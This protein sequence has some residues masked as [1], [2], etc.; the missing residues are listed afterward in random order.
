MIDKVLEQLF[1][2]G[3]L[4]V[5]GEAAAN[6]LT[7]HRI[8]HV[9]TLSITP[10]PEER[11]VDGVCYTF[12]QMADNLAQDIVGSKIISDA[13][14]LLEQAILDGGNVLVHSEEGNSRAPAIIAAFLMH[15]YKWTAEKALTFVRMKRPTINPNKS[16]VDQLKIYAHMHFHITDRDIV[17]SNE[18]RSWK[19]QMVTK[20][21]EMCSNAQK[22]HHWGAPV[23]KKHSED[24]LPAVYISE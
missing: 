5:Y 17:C 21:L 3:A 23:H 8:S 10:I 9:L 2:S 20:N 14:L 13:T 4:D 15:K 22:E 12:I 6:K 19:T 24:G 11:Q 7:A 16:F 18:Y 1:L